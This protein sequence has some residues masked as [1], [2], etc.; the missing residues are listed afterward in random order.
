VVVKSVFACLSAPW[1]DAAF[2]PRVV[3]VR[4][5][6]LNVVA[7][8]LSLGWGVNPGYTIESRLLEHVIEPLGLPDRPGTTAGAIAWWVAVRYA[9]LEHARA[10]AGSR[11]LLI[12]HDDACIDTNARFRELVE[13]GGWNWD[14]PVRTFLAESNTPGQG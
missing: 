4:R 3:V 10:E 14:S 13:A 2:Q 7:S 9:A 5:N 11:W 8:W 6:P 12:D 1:I